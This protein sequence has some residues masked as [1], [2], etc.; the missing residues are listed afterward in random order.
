MLRC[1]IL[2][3]YT[4]AITKTTLY[5]KNAEEKMNTNRQDFG[6]TA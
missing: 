1:V 2:K 3:L 5:A 6:Q 4:N